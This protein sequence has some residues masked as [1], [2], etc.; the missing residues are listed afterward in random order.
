MKL[1]LTASAVLLAAIMPALPA[2]ADNNAVTRADNGA[3][4]SAPPAGLVV[5]YSGSLFMIPVANIAISAVWPGETYSATAV[6][7]SG[8]LLR[9]FDDTNIEAGVSG[10]VQENELAPWRY[11]HLNHASG[12]GRI[13]GID[14]VE[15]RAVPDVEPPFGSM[16][17]PPAS[18]E[19]REGAV[20]PISGILSMML[21]APATANGNICS[22]RVPIFDGRAR[23]NLRLENGGMSDVSTRAYRGE[24][25]VCRAYV[26]P[27]SGYED[28]KR[29]TEDDT[30]RPVTMWLAPIEGLW[31]PVR[32]RA[33]TRI[34]NLT[35]NAV[36]LS[37]DNG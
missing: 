19:E 3:R 33:N 12:K 32:Y 18:D 36:R 17:D 2:S 22:G 9:W 7:Q 1:K 25:M 28:G 29:P 30:A 10:Y 14:F 23:Y 6:F 24:A 15:G 20:D 16:G 5:Q 27:I 31:V 34:G 4:M 8:G 26:E 13:V 11:Q 37:V 21:A 35:I